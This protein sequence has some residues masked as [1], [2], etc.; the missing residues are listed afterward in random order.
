MDFKFFSEGSSGIFN[1]LLAIVVAL[2]LY[3]FRGL[4]SELHEATKTGQKNSERLSHIEG[5]LDAKT[6]FSPMG[7]R[8]GNED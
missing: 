2:G 5:Y 4:R 1:S 8:M 6:S 7:K 3:I